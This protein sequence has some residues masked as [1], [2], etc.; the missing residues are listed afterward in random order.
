MVN[1]WQEFKYK[2]LDERLAKFDHNR[3]T[4]PIRHR[5]LQEISDH[6]DKLLEE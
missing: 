1:D 3:A 2:K 5:V 6:L 4:Y